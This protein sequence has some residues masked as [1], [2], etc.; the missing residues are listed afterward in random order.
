[1]KRFRESSLKSLEELCTMRIMNSGCMWALIKFSPEE[2][3]RNVL[4]M[5][6][7]RYRTTF[8]EQRL[9]TP[10]FEHSHSADHLN[11]CPQCEHSSNLGYIWHTDVTEVDPRM[12]DI[13]GG[14]AH[15][16]H[17][18]MVACGNCWKIILKH[19]PVPPPQYGFTGS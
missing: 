3:I 12:L 8:L 18:S 6:E 5:M 9:K 2:K 4:K 1:M 16:R 14:T 15:F 13:Y 17:K 19:Q 10:R 7:E 11:R